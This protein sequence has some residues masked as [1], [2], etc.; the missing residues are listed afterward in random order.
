MGQALYLQ[1][2]SMGQA[3]VM[4]GAKHGRL[5]QHFREALG[6]CFGYLKVTDLHCQVVYTLCHG[7]TISLILEV[8]HVYIYEAGGVTLV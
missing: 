8:G 4:T 2:P 3:I 1:V 6:L 7:S 5:T